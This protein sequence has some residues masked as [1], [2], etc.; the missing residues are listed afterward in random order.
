M[1]PA[2]RDPVRAPVPEGGPD[3]LPR[4]VLVR[5]GL[6]RSGEHPLATRLAGGVSSDIWRVDLPSGPV[7]VKRA[8]ARLRTARP[9]HAPPERSEHEVAWLEDAA[10]IVPGAVPR[11]VAHAPDEH[12]FV[13]EHLDP[14]THPVWKEQLLVG[15]VEP[16]TARAVAERVVAVH[17]ATADDPATA[18][19]FTTHDAFAALRLEPYLEA[20]ARAHPDLAGP[21]GT[22]RERTHRTRRVLVHGDVSPKNVLVGPDGPVLLDAECAVFGDPAFDLAFC[23]NHLLLKAVHRPGAADRLLD[24]ALLLARTYLDAVSWEDPADV[25]GRAAALLPALALARVDG[26]SP[27]EYLDAAERDRVRR[28]ARPLVATPPR[29]VEQVVAAWA[30]AAGEAGR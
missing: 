7:C 12:L 24:A 29:R 1:T 6:L 19:R 9:W 30:A 13:M 21:L 22:L 20:T 14:A 2:A 5:L 25:E 4:D 11:V 18:G 16:G 27:V 26:T 10:A 28:A 23:A 15:R 3:D 8:R 17:A